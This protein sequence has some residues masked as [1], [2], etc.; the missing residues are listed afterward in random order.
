[1]SFTLT[2]LKC[3]GCCRGVEKKLTEKY[4]DQGVLAVSVVLLLNKLK[5]SLSSNC[6]LTEQEIEQFL[7]SIG[8]RAV[9]IQTNLLSGNDDQSP[10]PFKRIKLTVK[11]MTSSAC[12]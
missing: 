4:G 12:E 9:H 3:A 10:S 1:M 11:G 8:K 2:N 7:D 5:M 6:A